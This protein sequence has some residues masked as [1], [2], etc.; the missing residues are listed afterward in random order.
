MS[1]TI[2]N[3]PDSAWENC[4]RWLDQ[5]KTPELRSVLALLNELGLKLSVTVKEELPV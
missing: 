1:G 5:G 3:E 2:L 4:D